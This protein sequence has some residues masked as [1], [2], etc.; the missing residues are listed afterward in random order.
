MNAK[1]SV[2]VSV[3]AVVASLIVSASVFATEGDLNL[4]FDGEDVLSPGNGKL[5]VQFQNSLN[6][7]AYAV[8]NTAD[9]G[10]VTAGINGTGDFAIVRYESDG[11]R[12]A[13][14]GALGV[15]ATDF[16]GGADDAYAVV[17]QSDGRIIAGGSSSD[18]NDTNFAIARYETNGTLDS[19]F[20]TGKVVTDL[21]AVQPNVNDQINAIALQDDGRIVV[22]GFT[23]SSWFGAHRFV[24]GR[25]NTNG[26]LDTSFDGSN[27]GNGIVATIVRAGFASEARAIAIQNDGKIVV[28]GNAGSHVAVVRYNEDGTLDTSFD[29]LSN[30]DGIVTTE[31]LGAFAEARSVQ[32]QDDGKIVV[33][34][35]YT[36]NSTGGFLILRYNSDGTLDA[37]FDGSNPQVPANGIL[38]LSLTTGIDI[39]SSVAIQD[40]GKIV[41]SGTACYQC[42][43][44]DQNFAIVRLRP[45]G[46]LDSSFANA[47]IVETD[48]G[49]RTDFAFA[50]AAQPNGDM[51]VVGDTLNGSHRDIALARYV[52][53]EEAPRISISRSGSG[54]LTTGDSVTLTFTLSE[55]VT[56]FDQSDI[57]VTNGALSNFSGSGKTFT[58]TVTP[59]AQSKGSMTV[60]VLENAFVD[61]ANNANIS[62]TPLV[63]E[64]DTTTN[65]GLEDGTTTSPSDSTPVPLTLRVRKT[66]TIRAIAVYSGLE[67]PRR[68]KISVKI[69]KASKK[70]CAVAGTKRIRGVKVGKCKMRVTVTA[71]NGVKRSKTTV[72]Q[73]V[74]R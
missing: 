9:S 71:K 28:V 19:S 47:G 58:A 53:D 5:I 57:E 7:S 27:N 74:R 44:G 67:V 46:S 10:L 61:K 17:V 21:S 29:G 59:P 62:P 49:A 16:A 4:G 43:N 37:T 22:A 14:F 38:T 8:A 72:V 20:S 60:A 42:V 69:V 63:I 24:L 65:T 45:D 64:F 32:I 39:G 35:Y 51:V 2:A 70:R 48:F 13:S 73:V 33:A 12:L 34:G 36:A 50:M 25:Y 66:A 55:V 68:A 11:K 1:R 18:G 54:A 56:T 31:V 40:D 6:Q 23:E 15:V 26:T 41:I 3:F 30:G 52:G